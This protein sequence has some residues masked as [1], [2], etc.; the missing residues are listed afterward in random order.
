MANGGVVAELVE[1]Y[2]KSSAGRTLGKL[3]Q[4]WL[5]AIFKIFA[6]GPDGHSESIA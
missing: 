1:R 4:A 3:E 5:A 2:Q 6:T